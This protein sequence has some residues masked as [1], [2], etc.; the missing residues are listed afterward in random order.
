M[1]NG[2]ALR[3]RR[4]G[5][6]LLCWFVLVAF[7]AQSFLVQSH[8]HMLQHAWSGSGPAVIASKNTQAPLDADK[9]F[10]C[11]EYLH[12]GVYLTPAAAAPLPPSAAVSLLPLIIA[13]LLLARAT[14][15]NWIG[16]APPRL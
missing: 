4:K 11:Q 10:L 5:S 12:G 1:Q 3:A 13:P 7:A 2:T 8:I 15:H 9:C 6:S 14:S 16:R